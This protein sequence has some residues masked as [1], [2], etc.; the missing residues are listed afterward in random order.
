MLL[1]QVASGF[2]QLFTGSTHHRLDLADG[3]LIFYGSSSKSSLWRVPTFSSFVD[4][5]IVSPALY[6]FP[7]KKERNRKQLHDL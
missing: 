5:D 1:L 4:F 7:P 2:E 6:V 3:L